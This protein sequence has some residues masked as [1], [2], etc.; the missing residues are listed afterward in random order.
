[1][2]TQ[3]TTQRTDVVLGLGQMRATNDPSLALVCLGLGSCVAVCMYDPIAQVAG[4]AHVV[5]PATTNGAAP[6]P[7]FADAAIPMLIEEMRGLGALK[8]RMKVKIV[9][10][11]QM[12][13]GDG[14]IGVMNIGDRNVEAV[15]SLLTA[16]G[17]ELQ[18]AETGGDHGRTARF[19]VD[20]STVLVSRA[21]GTSH[22]L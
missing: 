8:V 20:S 15:T 3:T 7:K 18:A 11:A 21:G 22:E 14:N 5:L 2:T 1:M 4:M 17:L 9:G 16:N 13:G 6:H 19:F 12:V 10:G